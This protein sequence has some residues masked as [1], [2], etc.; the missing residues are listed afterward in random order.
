MIGG[1]REMGSEP[2][3]RNPALPVRKAYTKPALRPYGTLE[4]ITH[5]QARSNTGGDNRSKAN[6]RTGG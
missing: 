4:S 6:H 1:S 2:E 3:G 5:F